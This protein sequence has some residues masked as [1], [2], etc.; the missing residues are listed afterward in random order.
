MKKK[1][2]VYSRLYPFKLIYEINEQV[3]A[4]FNIKEPFTPV[5]VYANE[6]VNS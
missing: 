1:I 4:N 3:L 6:K 2:L 5:K